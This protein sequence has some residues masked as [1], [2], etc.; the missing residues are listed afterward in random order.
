MDME[1]YNRQDKM[2]VLREELVALEEDR[3]AGRNGCMHEELDAYLDNII[4]EE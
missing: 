4:A 2:L 3:L 1:N